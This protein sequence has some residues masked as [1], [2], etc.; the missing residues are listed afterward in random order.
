MESKISDILNRMNDINRDYNALKREYEKLKRAKTSHSISVSTT[1]NEL[2]CNGIREYDHLHFEL[3]G[4]TAKA[5][6]ETIDTCFV[7]QGKELARKLKEMQEEL[8]N[9]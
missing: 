1:V 7:E 4:E 8:K 9:Q 2:K 5:V 6:L 3:K